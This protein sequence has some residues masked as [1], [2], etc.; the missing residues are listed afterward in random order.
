MSRYIERNLQMVLDS[1][2]TAKKVAYQKY[3]A[4]LIKWLQ[5]TWIG[6]NGEM[7][8]LKSNYAEKLK[9]AEA[10]LTRASIEVEHYRREVQDGEIH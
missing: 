7:V 6:D 1:A 8:V 10:E 4:M 9:E 3:K 2:I 5:S